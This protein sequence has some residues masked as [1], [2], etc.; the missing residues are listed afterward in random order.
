MSPKKK[1]QSHSKFHHF[2]LW[3]RCFPKT[4][5]SWNASQCNINISAC[6]CSHTHNLEGHLHCSDWPAERSAPLLPPKS[7][8]C[9]ST[10][11]RCPIPLRFS[12]SP[13]DHLVFFR[14]SHLLPKW[15]NG[16]GEIKAEM[17]CTLSSARYAFWGLQT[18]KQAPELTGL[19]VSS[20]YQLDDRLCLNLYPMLCLAHQMDLN[21]REEILFF[22][23]CG[24]PA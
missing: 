18:A 23:F 16:E 12:S 10:G 1:I 9:C 4:F 6:Q 24:T 20:R 21:A 13:P 19:V 17:C 15:D 8:C 5:F 2:T 14:L 3:C 11:H 22:F 7:V